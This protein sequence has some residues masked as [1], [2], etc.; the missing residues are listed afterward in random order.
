M[1]FSID[2]S[3]LGR[4]VDIGAQFNEGM[5]R[6][7]AL[8]MRGQQDSALA[9][10]ARDPSNQSAL[11]GLTAV[12]P[13]LGTRMQRS[14]LDRQQAS[15]RQSIGLQA[16]RGDLAGART[17]ALS[18]G[19]IDYA[20]QLDAMSDD[21]RKELGE[22]ANLLTP[23]YRQLSE[24]P[25]EAR[26]PFLVSIAPRLAAHG[27]PADVIANYDPSDAN[28]QTDIALGTKAASATV[29]NIQKE[30]DY[31]RGLG[32]NDLA[33]QLLERHAEG[34]PMTVR[35]EDGTITIIPS[36]AARAGQVAGDGASDPASLR[37]QADEAIRRG[38]DPAAVNARL[39][40][41][42]KGGPSQAGSGTF[43]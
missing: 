12:N 9:T 5:E 33:E 16:A 23:I 19:D 21:Q 35:N 15:T 38:A 18:A 28:L 20:K 32:R 6:G 10:L 34:P 22:T 24:M 41:M 37:A 8:R 11:A 2:W 31:Y 42:L 13:E 1:T 3:L 7:R 36:A 40:E 14:T 27:I 26:K 30:V 43:P 25:Y 4:P 29:T 39:E 17:A